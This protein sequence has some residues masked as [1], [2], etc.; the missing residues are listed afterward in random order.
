LNTTADNQANAAVEPG[1]GN[2]RKPRRSVGGL[3]CRLGVLLGL[4]G[5]AAS[6]LGR[7]WIAFDVFSQFTVH[8]A[9]VAVAF[10]L[11]LLMPRGKLF[12][13]FLIFLFGLVA[14][15]V[16]PYLASRMPETFA[17]AAPGERQITAAS[18]NTLWVNDD[19]DAVAA[20]VRRIDADVMTL[21]E[22]GPSK[23]ALIERV[24]DRFPYHTDCYDIAFCNLVILSKFPIAESA[25]RALWDGPP[26]IWAR[27]G[28]EAGGLTVFGVHT[29]RFPHARAQLRQANE[30]A[31]LVAAMPGRKLVM[32][33]F[34][35]TPFSRI[36]AVVA[37]RA[38][39]QRL[40]FLPSWPSTLGLPQLA[41]DHIFA[42]PGVRLVESQQIGEP[43]GSDHFP[44]V[45]KIAVPLAP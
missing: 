45:V 8:F 2:P 39:L 23:R 21:I 36:T 12:T 4:A 17:P 18:F 43:A 9:L 38:N 14:I 30:I 20:E 10:L 7:L 13:A 5:L 19:V 42:S 41:I 29:I 25:A 3:E 35:A 33:D 27:L 28:P 16:W 34:N 11:G 31:D 40:T 22:M 32:G 24:K 1:Q 44:V 15:G 37:G 26:Y 6:R